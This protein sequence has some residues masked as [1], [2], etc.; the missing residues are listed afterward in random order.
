MTTGELIVVAIFAGG[1]LCSLSLLWW[2]R[3]LIR[4]DGRNT[5]ATQENDCR[6]SRT[7]APRAD[8][9]ENLR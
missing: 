1:V 8:E 7:G 3:R 9:R 5:G 6:T 2:L 4:Q